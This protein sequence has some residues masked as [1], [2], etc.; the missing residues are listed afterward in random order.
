MP[1]P[2]PIREVR[3]KPELPVKWVI[4]DRLLTELYK[5]VEESLAE[6]IT[7]LITRN[8]LLLGMEDMK[9]HKRVLPEHF[10]RSF[11]YNGNFYT[12]EID[13]GPPVR[14]R[15]HS[16]L[17]GEMVQHEAY[18][19]QVD[20]ERARISGFFDSMLAFSPAP[21]DWIRILPESLQAALRGMLADT[22]SWVELRTPQEIS[23]FLEKHKPRFDLIRQRMATNLL[24]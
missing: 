3:N 22:T 24:L 21:A 12:V 8:V 5:P 10:H 13:A 2:H 14:N 7:S 23:A 18:C 19:I 1:V 16:S 17:E 6:E 11:A 4:R 20:E 15:L 9:V